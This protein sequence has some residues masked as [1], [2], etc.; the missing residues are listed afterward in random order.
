M[1]DQPDYEDFLFQQDG[2][3]PHWKT[4]VRDFLDQWLPNHWI[5]RG[6]PTA[7][8]PNSP[9]LTPC[10]FFLWGFIRQHVYRVPIQNL[11]HLKQRIKFVFGMVTQ[12]MLRAT[13][14]Q[15]GARLELLLAN[16]GGH[17]EE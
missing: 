12:E 8:P 2:A 16:Q 1:A 7:W 14:D 15:M 5:G 9:D 10:D 3:P 6:G 11:D 4:E 17:V 13:W